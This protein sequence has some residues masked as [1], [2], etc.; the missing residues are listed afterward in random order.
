MSIKKVDVYKKCKLPNTSNLYQYH[1]NT[2][3]YYDYYQYNTNNHINK[4]L[5]MDKENNHPNKKV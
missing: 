5:T 2:K 4:S 1:T 3:L